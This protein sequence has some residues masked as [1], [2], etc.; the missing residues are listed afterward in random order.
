MDASSATTSAVDRDAQGLHNG[1]FRR[2][3]PITDPITRLGCAQSGK[4][5]T[6]LRCVGRPDSLPLTNKLIN[7]NVK[8]RSNR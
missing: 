1:G 6:A 7:K 5:A 2:T 3:V 8:I 4:A